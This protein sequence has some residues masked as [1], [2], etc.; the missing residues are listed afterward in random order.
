MAVL[1]TKTE[2]KCKLCSHPNRPEIDVLL[3][4]RSKGET[5][6][7]GRR[8]NG[9]YVLEILA[10]WGVKN[11]TLE[12]IK[13]HFGK[14]CEVVSATTAEEAEKALSD[15]NQGMLA[16]LDES[17]GSVDSDLRAIFKLGLM[18]IRGRVLRGE[19]PGV[20]VDHSMKA[21][22]ELTKRQHNEAGRELLGALVGGIASAIAKPKEPKQIGRAEVIDAEAV[23]E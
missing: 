22:A 3:E 4:K 5:D 14:H 15:L 6:D 18:Q 17:D 9:E 2:P 8:F 7:K 23:E 1:A 21:A 16:V 11:P 20:T 19:S 12:N 10:T 13:T